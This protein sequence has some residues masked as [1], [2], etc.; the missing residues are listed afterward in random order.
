MNSLD[1]QL[2]L[3]RNRL[4]SVTSWLAICFC[5]LTTY[6]AIQAGSFE[7]EAAGDVAAQLQVGVAGAANLKWM[8]LSDTFGFYLFSIPAAIYL[9]MNF[10]QENPF[11]VSLATVAGIFFALVGAIGASILSVAWPVLTIATATAS[12]PSA[13]QIY[14]ELF[15]V[16]TMFVQDGMWGRLE[17]FLSGVWYV[18]LALVI[19]PHRKGFATVTFL[20]GCFGLLSSAAKILDA[21]EIAGLGLQ[22]VLY[23]TPI[24]FFWLGVLA[25]KGKSTVAQSSGQ[26]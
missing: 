7:Y 16:I 8:M 20:N 6:L 10:K 24:W 18:G 11:L 15:R 25:W 1:K 2:V 17:F 14:T 13:A 22:G 12:D 19:W 21:G 26:Q 3:S 23:A 9:W 5:M 4:V